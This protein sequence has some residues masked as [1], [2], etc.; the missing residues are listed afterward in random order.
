MKKAVVLVL[1]VV[2]AMSMA[3]PAFAVNSPVAPKANQNA[4][5]SLPVVVN[6]EEKEAVVIL[7][8][9]EDNKKL[10]EEAQKVFAE[11]QS[12]LKKAVPAGMTPK[13][14]FYA[15]LKID[16]EAQAT[17][18]VAGVK[19]AS[20]IVVKQ[21]IDGEWVELEVEIDAKGNVLI[22]GIQEGPMLICTK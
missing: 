5:A 2:L 22:K 7:T 6:E 20:D 4:T 9:V 11:A 8:A 1:A 19:Q 3:V 15:T 13:Y 10:P 17:I 18:K 16:G 12:D 14:F 21:F